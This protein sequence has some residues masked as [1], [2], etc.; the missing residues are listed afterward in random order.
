VVGGVK[1]EKTTHGLPA[2]ARDYDTVVPGGVVLNHVLRVLGHDI[3][4]S[5]LG[6]R[7]ERC[8]AMTE[9]VLR[10]SHARMHVPERV[11]VAKRDGAKFRDVTEI[12]IETGVG[13]GRMIV[14][15]RPRAWLLAELAELRTHGGRMVVAGTPNLHAEGFRAAS[16]PILR[17]LSSPSVRGLLLGGDTVAELPFA[18]P[19]STGGGSALYFLHCGD[20]PVLQALRRQRLERPTG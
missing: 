2:F 20:L 9:Q 10:Q 17:T 4:D 6:P 16:E 3:G 8:I 18:G 7:P 5:S 1:P 19:K 12:P 11:I 15:F 13:A 14:D